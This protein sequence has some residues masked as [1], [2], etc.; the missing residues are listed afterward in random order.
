MSTNGRQSSVEWRTPLRLIGRH[1]RLF[2][3]SAR[4]PKLSGHVERAERIHT[5]GF[6]ELCN[7]DLAMAPSTGPPGVGAPLL[8]GPPPATRWMSAVPLS[9][10]HSAF[11][12]WSRPVFLIC[13]ERVQLMPS[14]SGTL[15]R[16]V[17]CVAE[18]ATQLPSKG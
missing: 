7:G 6:Y 13:P 10:L 2:V 5:E 12:A 3:L 1:L 15:H 9:I 16:A 11:Q 18:K 17:D 14:R 4:S 8:H